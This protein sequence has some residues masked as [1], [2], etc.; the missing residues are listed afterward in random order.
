[1]YFEYLEQENFEIDKKMYTIPADCNNN[2]YNCRNAM[3]ELHNLFDRS[4]LE[5][6]MNMDEY[7]GW[8]KEL[9]KACKAWDG[10]Y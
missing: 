4:V 1:M 3:F 6:K 5:M 7:Q 8:K 10:A 9:Q 2:M